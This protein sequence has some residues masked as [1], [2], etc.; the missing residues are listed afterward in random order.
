[1]PNSYWR[2]RELDHIEQTIRD[3]ART[4]RRIRSN[5]LR[6][7]D[8]IESQIEAFYG[9]YASAEG[10]TT[11]EARK[12]VTRLD[13]DRYERK[14]RRYVRDRDFS[15][16]ANEE[17]RLYNVTMRINRL[18]ML[19]ANIHLELLAMTSEEQRILFESMT[20]SARAEYE[21][22]AGILGQTLN[23]NE[24]SIP[25]IVNSSFLTATWSDRL[26]DNQDALRSELDRLLNRGVVQGL[27]P[28][29]LARELRNRFDTSIYNS[30]RLLRTEM[31]RVQQDAFQD[32]MEQAEIEQYEYIAEPTACDICSALD[33]GV[34]NVEDA[35]PG[36]NAYP[37][38][39][40]C[41]CSQAAY[42]DREA[43]ERDL[44]ARGL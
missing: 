6:A 18:E 39:P 28:R 36:R 38:H 23:Y 3:D 9:S 25:T 33:G 4:A 41:R 34:F 17:M 43:F 44:E 8:E 12:R 29:E 22:Q 32:S 1:M 10:I 7:M 14:A 31:A 21:R 20:A 42:V 37:M 15:R 30:E 2:Q 24:R 13:I 5:Q 26:W 35:E 11:E 16:R 19:K 27:N 40:N